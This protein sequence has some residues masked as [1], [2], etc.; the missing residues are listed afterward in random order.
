MVSDIPRS[1]NYCTNVAN[2]DDGCWWFCRLKFLP[3]NQYNSFIFIFIFL[4]FF[5]I[6]P[7]WRP[8]EVLNILNLW[9]MLS[10]WWIQ[11]DTDLI[12][13]KVKLLIDFVSV[14]IHWFLLLLTDYP[15]LL[16]L[17]KNIAILLTFSFLLYYY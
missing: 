15:K 12:C 2:G 10:H 4:W 7:V 8:V 5:K 14:T 13:V 9:C 3:S 11:E 16:V 6:V 17:F 1:V